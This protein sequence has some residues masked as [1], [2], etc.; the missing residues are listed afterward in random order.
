[1]A[2]LIAR[3]LA[4][5]IVAVGASCGEPS[6]WEEVATL[7]GDGVVIAQRSS[8]V[9]VHARRADDV[10]PAG[11]FARVAVIDAALVSESPDAALIAAALLSDD[12]EAT[13]ALADAV[14]AS[15][16][17]DVSGRDVVAL[18][19]GLDVTAAS[20]E[21]ADIVGANPGIELDETTWARWTFAEGRAEDGSRWLGWVLHRVD[22]ERF[23][24][25]VGAEAKADA[26]DVAE[27]ANLAV[28]L[29]ARLPAGE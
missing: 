6:P 20:T 28:D 13:D 5:A 3:V 19:D 27:A 15:I 8:G 11:T 2:R 26:A 25:V 1:V 7:T 29:L 16:P 9:D 24:L 23:V 21:L 12:A 17:T 14:S 10:R 4:I 22:G 18:I